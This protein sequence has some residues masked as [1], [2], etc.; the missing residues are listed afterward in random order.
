MA[1]SDD[2]NLAIGMN[3]FRVN[4][5]IYPLPPNQYKITGLRHATLSTSDGHYTGNLSAA[6]SKKEKL[7]A[8]V[9]ILVPT[10]FE[11]GVCAHFEATFYAAGNVLQIAPYQHVE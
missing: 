11:P 4:S 9:Y 8:G 2:F 1:N 5:T 7:A 3:L 10:T 6:V